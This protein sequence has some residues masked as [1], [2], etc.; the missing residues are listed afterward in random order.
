MKL[1]QFNK[2]KK[3]QWFAWYPV[4]TTRDELIWL[5]TV[6]VEERELW[7]GL[8]SYVEYYYIRNK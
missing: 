4:T 7:D 2:R 8:Y 6:T 1:F 5:E 3:S